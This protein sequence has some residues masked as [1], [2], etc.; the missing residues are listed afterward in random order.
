M[1]QGTILSDIRHMGS[2]LVIYCEVKS[3]NSLCSC[4]KQSLEDHK[5]HS[6]HMDHNTNRKQWVL[7]K[8]CWA[9][10]WP[11]VCFLPYRNLTFIRG[12]TSLL[13][14]CSRLPS[15]LLPSSRPYL[16]GVLSEVASF[17][18]AGGLIQLWAQILRHQVGSLVDDLI[19]VGPDV[20]QRWVIQWVFHR[21]QV[22]SPV[23]P[24]SLLCSDGDFLFMCVYVLSPCFA[25]FSE[26]V[27]RTKWRIQTTRRLLGSEQKPDT[28]HH[29]PLWICCAET[30]LPPHTFY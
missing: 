9:T 26:T 5:I 2:W 12:K 25:P 15:T 30:C 18:P 28:W 6:R 23:S 10:L 11:C 16:A 27:Q 3:G 19:E 4:E 7:E 22:F 24:M 14:W 21:G 13:R 17:C 20:N 1:S 8:A 29:W